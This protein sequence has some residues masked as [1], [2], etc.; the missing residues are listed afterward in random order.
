M[1]S[2]LCYGGL[3]I[4]CVKRIRRPAY[5]ISYRILNENLRQVGYPAEGVTRPKGRITPELSGT[6]RVTIRPVS[7][8]GIATS[9]RSAASNPVR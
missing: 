7:D 4:G 1:G 9:E 6:Y 2:S 3:R 8:T 5:R